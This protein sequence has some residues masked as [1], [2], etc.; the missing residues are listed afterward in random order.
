VAAKVPEVN[1]FELPQPAPEAPTA[2]LTGEA[3]AAR[4]AVI[5]RGGGAAFEP[6]PELEE[7]TRPR[8]NQSWAQDAQ[9]DSADIELQR[10]IQLSQGIALPQTEEANPL[11]KPK[12]TPAILH[13]VPASQSSAG[14]AGESA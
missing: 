4:S 7:H 11:L 3:A 13:A 6:E 10:A 14:A 12:P 8:P 9:A 2:T 1:V 5:D